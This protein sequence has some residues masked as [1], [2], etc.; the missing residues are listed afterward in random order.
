MTV[1]GG[2]RRWQPMGQDAQLFFAAAACLGRAAEPIP[3][4]GDAFPARI[5][6]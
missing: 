6:I 2:G 5:G 1:V 3:G 4:S